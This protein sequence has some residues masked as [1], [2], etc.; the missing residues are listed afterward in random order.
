MAISNQE[1]IKILHCELCRLENVESYLLEDEC[2]ADELR[3]IEKE[4][5]AYRR[6]IRYLEKYGVKKNGNK[7]NPTDAPDVRQKG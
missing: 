6:A 7:K 2:D 1:C 5:E 4:M 3:S